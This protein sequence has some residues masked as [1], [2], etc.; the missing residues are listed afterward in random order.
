MEVPKVLMKVARL[1]LVIRQFMEIE[2]NSNSS[3]TSQSM[4]NNNKNNQTQTFRM[5]FLKKEVPVL[6]TFSVRST[7]C[8]Q[9]VGTPAKYASEWLCVRSFIGFCLHKNLDPNRPEGNSLVEIH[10]QNW[11]NNTF[12]SKLFLSA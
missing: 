11:P 9:T 4:C 6:N 7:R 3:L 12:T 10:D 5:S 2:K 8:P 1:T